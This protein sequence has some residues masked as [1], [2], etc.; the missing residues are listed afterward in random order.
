M[1]REVTYLI[2][3][4]PIFPVG[5]LIECNA[6]TGN[7]LLHPYGQSAIPQIVSEDHIYLRSMLKVAEKK[8]D[9]FWENWL[10]YLPPQLNFRNKWYHER[11]NIEVGDFVINLEPGLK[12]KTAPRGQWKK[13]TV[14]E[15]H[16][17]KDGL[18]RSVTICTANGSQYKRP[19]H[20]LCLIATRAE[21][22]NGLK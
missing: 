6:L 3:S 8:V 11:S 22:E 18:V 7:S 2:N 5:D 16:P 13:A 12:N 14:S 17:S 9:C 20:K 4:R 19:I 21:L 10:K 1:L 15:V